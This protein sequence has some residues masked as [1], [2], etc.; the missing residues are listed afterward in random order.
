MHKN[1][2]EDFP[3]LDENKLQWEIFLLLKVKLL[4]FFVYIQTSTYNQLQVIW[5]VFERVVKTNRNNEITYV[6]EM[7]N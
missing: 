5:K 6:K 2:T 3:F 1:A 4:G 7:E